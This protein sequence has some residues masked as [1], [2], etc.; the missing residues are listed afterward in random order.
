MA[1]PDR[2]HGPSSRRPVHR[3]PPL[4]EHVDPATL[5]RPDPHGPLVLLGG[6]PTPPEALQ[7]AV[8]LSDVP[9]EAK[10]AW[11]NAADPCCRAWRLPSTAVPGSGARHHGR[12][13]R[14][15]RQGSRHDPQVV[16]TLEQADIVFLDG[17][18]TERLYR[19]LA[20]TPA[21]DTLVALSRRGGVVM[22]YSAGT[23]LLG[24]GMLTR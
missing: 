8:D 11:V 3:T 1:G 15:S 2:R 9:A 16:A 22:G 5:P 24:A 20:A 7:T 13:H 19:A 6:G 4:L 12:R 14:A 23:T 21:L 18:S 17:G 10:V